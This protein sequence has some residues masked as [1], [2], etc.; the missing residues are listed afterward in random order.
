MP[1]P[2]KKYVN[3]R[4][5]EANKNAGASEEKS[6]SNPIQ[7]CWAWVSKNLG[8]IGTGKNYGLIALNVSPGGTSFLYESVM[9]MGGD[10]KEGLLKCAFFKDAAGPWKGD[11]DPNKVGEICNTAAKSVG[12][13]KLFGVPALRRRRPLCVRAYLLT[14]PRRRRP[15][16]LTM[17]WSRSRSA[18]SQCRWPMS[19]CTSPA[20]AS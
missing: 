5:A 13:L 20:W 10:F 3:E 7:T 8:W 9:N 19:P 11:T 12:S 16:A 6:S 15:A 1:Q 14:V 4:R 18:H 2:D 17:A